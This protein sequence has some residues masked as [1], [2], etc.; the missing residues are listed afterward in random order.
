MVKTQGTSN[1]TNEA[2]DLL[3]VNPS[4]DWKTEKES[5]I[6]M[7]VN[8]NVS[9]QETPHIGIAYMLA[10]AKKNG[11]K[12]KYI[13]MVM[14]DFSVDDL[15]SFIEKYKPVLTGFTAFTVQIKA[16]G[17]IAKQIKMKFPNSKICV[18]GPHVTAIPKESL[19]EF[20]ALDFVICGEGESI[21]SEIVI[22][23]KEGRD[24]AGIKGV[25]TR[26]TG[27]FAWNFCEN[28]EELP[29][30]AW[31]EFDISK[32]PGL[33]PHRTKLE[34][35]M[36]SGRGCPFNCVF[37]C[38]ALGKKA[39]KRSVKSVIA[40]IER[41]VEV[42]GCES[43]SF[44]DDTF[45]INIQWGEEFFAAMEA[46]KLNKKVTWSC[47]T[48]VDNLTPELLIKMKQ[49][50]CYYV[51]YGIESG[52]EDTLKIIKK[53][54]TLDKVNKVVNWSKD[55]GI[56]PVGAFIIGLP[57]DTEKHV[58]NNIAFATELNLFSVTFPIAVPFPGTE[59]REMALRNEFGMKILSN[60]WDHYGKQGHGVLESKELPYA[61]RIELKNLAYKTHPKK[62]ICEYI[63]KYLQK[64]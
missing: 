37:C 52:N 16:A 45:L 56:I 54:I 11:L 40:E 14:D 6:S 13:D 12:V 18:G 24:I 31:E 59:L 35:P 58:M 47:S 1:S 60:N 2:L 44:M 42:F 5:K 34:L 29:F 4:L 61:K 30:P 53:S 46:K 21:I 64:G 22:K 26:E 63:G 41:N 39:R 43:I 55:A 38:R 9:N 32:Y 23:L 62:D 20:K 28:I 33:Y 25:V 49:S 48:R 17:L 15:L 27:D 50:G 51:F 10:M 7:R 36:V 57:G 3:L 19:N 8:K